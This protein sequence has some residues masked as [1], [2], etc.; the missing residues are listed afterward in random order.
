M[1]CANSVARTGSEQRQQTEAATQAADTADYVRLILNALQS[2]EMAEALRLANQAV[3]QF[4]DS[5]ALG[6][7]QARCLLS[8]GRLP[9]AEVAL[10][11]QLKRD[12]ASVND[13][14][15]LGIAE[16]ELHGSDAARPV[17]QKA[18]ALDN[19]AALGYDLLGNLDLRSGNYQAAAENFRTAAELAP[20]RDL[21]A[22]G[23]ALA[24]ERLGRSEEALVFAEKAVHLRPDRATNRFLL[25]KLYARAGKQDTALEQLQE[26]VRLNPRADAA[27]Y[28]LAQTYRRAGNQAA[29]DE[30]N[31]R[32]ERLQQTRDKAV[33]L[34]TPASEALSL[35][36]PPAPWDL[37][38]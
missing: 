36:Q 37:P 31:R 3:Q 12:P 20:A 28:L 29:A 8:A 17:I 21:Y 19:H 15:M 4:P 27:Y 13:N 30:W 16:A 11:R 25:G 26:C 7:L 14:L 35:D 5:T 34:Q 2:G 24:L 1:V 18:L 22:Y 23:A 38:K 32:Y 6:S 9:E 10:R 33:G